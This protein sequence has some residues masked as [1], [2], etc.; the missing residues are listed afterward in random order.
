MAK[1]PHSRRILTT[2]EVLDIVDFLSGGHKPGWFRFGSDLLALSSGAQELLTNKLQY[3]VSA[4]RSDHKWHTIAYA[5][6]G[7]D[8]FS[9]L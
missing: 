9:S 2:G 8:G 1:K 5:F 7:Y 6:A 4:T 3:T